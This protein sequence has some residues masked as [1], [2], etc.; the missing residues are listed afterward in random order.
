M[1]AKVTC[2]TTDNYWKT[3]N[4][5]KI[6]VYAG[7][8]LYNLSKSQPANWVGACVHNAIPLGLL[9]PAPCQ[10]VHLHQNCVLSMCVQFKLMLDHAPHHVHAQ[11]SSWRFPM[12]P[13]SSVRGT[14]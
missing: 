6:L 3:H 11:V 5:G 14:L 1:S 2:T 9:F 8:P 7:K 12:S 10:A 13:T 4:G